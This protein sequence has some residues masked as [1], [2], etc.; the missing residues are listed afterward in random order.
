MHRQSE[1]KR[2]GGAVSVFSKK[3]DLK[4]VPQGFSTIAL[5]KVRYAGFVSS[6]I[7]G[8]RDQMCN[9]QGHKDSI[10]RQGDF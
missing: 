4:L 7:G 3:G 9:L 2:G 1:A 8:V 5:H 6:K 10:V